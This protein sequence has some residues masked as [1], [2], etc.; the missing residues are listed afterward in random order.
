MSSLIAIKISPL[1][2]FL[3]RLTAVFTVSKTKDKSRCLL[4]LYATTSLLNK[5]LIADK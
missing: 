5:S 1:M 2:L 3:F 4:T